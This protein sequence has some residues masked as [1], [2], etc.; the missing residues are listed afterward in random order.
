MET[1]GSEPAT[2]GIVSRFLSHD[3]QLRRNGSS[4]REQRI[5]PVGC[6]RRHQLTARVTRAVLGI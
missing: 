1:V 5:V 3:R 2:I 6:I 4:Q